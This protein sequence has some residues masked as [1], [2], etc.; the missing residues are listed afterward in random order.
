MNF[1]LLFHV[2]HLLIALAFQKIPRMKKFSFSFLSLIV[3]GS[4]IAQGNSSSELL[5]RIKQLKNPT[6][7]LYLA[8]HPDDENTRMISWLANDIGA[9]TAYLSLTRGDGGQNLIGTELGAQLG[10]LRTQ[11]LMQARAIDGGRQ[12]FSRAVDFGYSKNPEETFSQWERDVV[13]SDV[14]RVI[15]Q[16]QPHIIITRFPPDARA[17]HGHHTASAMLALEAFKLAAKGDAF[18]E[19]NLKPWRTKRIFWNHS[20]WW[21]RNIDSLAAADPSYFVVDVGT[22]LPEL[23]LSC[24]EMASYSRS[25]HKSQGFG[26]AVARGSS[27]EYLK[28][29]DGE[30]PES[31]IFDNIPQSWEEA[32]KSKWAAAIN[33]IEEAFD[34]HAPHKIVP[35]IIDAIYTIRPP[36]GGGYWPYSYLTDELRQLAADALG[37]KLELLAEQEY[38]VAGQPIKF[39]ARAIQRSPLKVKVSSLTNNWG[40]PEVSSYH[41][42]D[43][44]PNELV[45]EE[46]TLYLPKN[47]ESQPYWLR[48]PYG[49]MFKVAKPSL[50]GD[51]ENAP[52]YRIGVS[53]DIGDKG[54]SMDVPARYKFSDRVEGEI[55]RPLMIVPEITV[56][57]AVSK[58]FFLNDDE[59]E[60]SL[61][62]RAFKAG[63]YTINVSA[64]NWKVEPSEIRLKFSESNQWQSVNLKVKPGKGAGSNNLKIEQRI[65]SQNIPGE[66]YR[67]YPVKKLV[68]I[69][70]SHIDK[71]M[72]LEEPD[73]RLISLPLKRKGDKVAYVMGAGDKVAEAI[74]QMGY[75]VDLLDE[76]SLREADL[77]QY[78]AVVIGIRAYNT[79]DWLF[80]RKDQL[81]EYMRAGGNVIVQYNTRSRSFQGS[82]FSPYPFTISRQ[83]VTEE[84]AAVKFLLPKHPVLNEPNPISQADFDAWV[85]ERGLYFAD[86]W[87]PAFERPLAWHDKG[88]SDLE[89]ALLIAKVGKGSFMYTG[90]SFFRE[91][92]AGVT[93]AYRLLANL[94]S[95]EHGGE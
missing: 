18:P 68:E 89:G 36:A 76:Q 86:S 14:V 72:I 11:E 65:D 88:E 83:R 37:L 49:A 52:A 93:G 84:D 6:R 2:L 55:E 79:Q 60:V 81:E 21:Q 39:K 48:E 45:E 7:V 47:A 80:N 19:Q 40:K 23:G 33:K 10:V 16:F 85:Q 27:K 67:L 77:K 24:N 43:L 38:A 59:K 87:D 25:Q 74:A 51:P 22:Y 63:E 46:I 28:L 31:G 90:I 34:P 17:G 78:Q 29:M 1:S 44:V 62:F 92:P 82:D 35:H 64:E 50:I 26:V 70:Y 13:L 3:C 56:Q 69:D 95:Y 12:Y 5:H 61:D 57:S 9:Q 15:R 8:A 58:L 75:E 54:F 41:T 32:G 4:I 42:T 66:S 94:I 91:L 30:M 73:I 20:S 53:V 71:R